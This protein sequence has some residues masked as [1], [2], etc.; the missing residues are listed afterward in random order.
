M[1]RNGSAYL[2][3]GPPGPR[4]GPTTTKET[5]SVNTP[6]LR[7]VALTAL[8]ACA[9]ATAGAAPIEVLFV[10]NSYTFG[11][12]DPVMS[13]NAANVTDL[14]APMAAANATGS[15]SFEPH[16][17][18]GVAGI[19]KQFTAEA[20]LDYRVSLSTRNAASLRGHFLNNNPAGWDLRGNIAS[21]SWD[22]VVL[23]EQSDESL[24]KQPGL[25]SN[26]AYFRAYA[27]LI[28]NFVHQGNALSYRERDLIGGT[29]AACADITGASTTACNT[30]RTIAANP[31]ANANAEVYLYQTWARPNLVN[32][33]FT[34]VTDP[35]TGKVS[36][37]T[38]PAT[39]YYGSLDAMTADLRAAYA[40]AAAAAGADNSGGVKGVAPVGDAFMRA[41]AM[42]VATPNHYAPDGRPD[43][44]WDDGTHASKYGS[45]LSA[46]TLFGTLTQ[47]DPASLGGNEIAAR[48]LG[49]SQA[50]ALALQRVA[51][52]QL[53]F[54]A[55]AQVPEPAGAALVAVAGLAALGAARRRRRTAARSA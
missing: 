5:D 12:V 16:P 36:F 28:E 37:T 17:W 33:P 51:S 47:L 25:A 46:L 45:Y 3:D 27:N 10:G 49:I 48:D 19:F 41:I 22:K 8:L 34:T 14:T 54:G 26:P 21:R 15:N 18:G 1:R 24:P 31:N 20:G 39:S 32:A 11:R 9:A 30:L 7:A 38:T 50:D 13:Y 4:I 44:W 52:L 6:S 29:A 35:V 53:G 55:T 23:Q 43:L 40:T 42:G 2:I